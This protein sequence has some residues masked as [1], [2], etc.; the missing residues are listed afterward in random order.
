MTAGSSQTTRTNTQGLSSQSSRST[1]RKSRR[2]KKQPVSP[3]LEPPTSISVADG[4]TTSPPSDHQVTT[5]SNPMSSLRGNTPGS[6]E[7]PKSKD[8]IKRLLDPQENLSNA[9]LLATLAAAD[10]ANSFS[11][12]TIDTEAAV[13]SDKSEHSGQD[14]F[15]GQDEPTSY[16]EAKPTAPVQPLSNPS[17]TQQL[18]TALSKFSYRNLSPGVLVRTRQGD[19]G[20]PSISQG[21][22]ISVGGNTLP[23]LDTASSINA[24][25]NTDA[26]P[27]NIQSFDQSLTAHLANI[28]VDTAD[29]SL[30]D[31]QPTADGITSSVDH[32]PPKATSDTPSVVSATNFDTTNAPSPNSQHED[33]IAN[34]CTAI[35]LEKHRFNAYMSSCHLDDIQGDEINKFNA[36]VEHYRSTIQ[37]LYYRKSA[38]KKSLTA[39]AQKVAEWKEAQEIAK[40]DFFRLESSLLTLSASRLVVGLLLKLLL[41]E[42][43]VMGVMMIAPTTAH[44]PIR[45]LAIIEI[46]FQ[47]LHLSV[48]VMMEA[49]NARILLLLLVV[50]AVATMVVAVEATTATMM[51]TLHHDL[52]NRTIMEIDQI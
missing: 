43:L 16:E 11:T 7:T 15:V 48:L 2:R 44:L 33:T 26:T 24:T 18:Q 1:E 10:Q 19:L 50:V 3:G 39:E 13:C 30:N 36:C 6:K 29:L 52:V 38:L 27:S 9:E 23:I 47:T 25:L 20:I 22:P 17:T 14:L 8:E 37:N 34:L 40:S 32:A 49:T 51:L 28:I 5:S 42:A 31:D 35:D 12:S 46:K 21:G 41:L 4:Q 45:I